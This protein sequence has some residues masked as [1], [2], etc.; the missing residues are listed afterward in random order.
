MSAVDQQTIS[1][2]IVDDCAATR[3]KVRRVL[4]KRAMRVTEAENGEVAI[5]LIQDCEPFDLVL[6]DWDMP[7]MTGLELLGELQ[8]D[9]HVAKTKKMMVSGFY[10]MVRMLIV[11][12][13]H[14][15]WM[16]HGVKI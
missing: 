5:Q 16:R 6:V 15:C 12:S 10:K 7:G 13:C 9:T 11:P 1:V 14:Y 4:E 8:H 2:L 3:L